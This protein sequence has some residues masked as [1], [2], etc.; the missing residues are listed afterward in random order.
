[1]RELNKWKSKSSSFEVRHKASENGIGPDVTKTR[2]R[3]RS[4]KTLEHGPLSQIVKPDN[5]L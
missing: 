3:T 2:E 4:L 5:E 1:M